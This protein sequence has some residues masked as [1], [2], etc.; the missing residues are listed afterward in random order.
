MDVNFTQFNNTMTA[1]RRS[2]I[3]AAPTQ[4]DQTLWDVAYTCGYNQMVEPDRE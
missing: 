3:G 1:Q 4:H 2:I